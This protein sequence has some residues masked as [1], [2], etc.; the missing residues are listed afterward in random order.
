M[1]KD[2]IAL[3]KTVAVLGTVVP[4]LNTEVSKTQIV[5][6]E[7]GSHIHTAGT[8]SAI[9]ILPNLSSSYSAI[10]SGSNLQDS[11]VWLN[12]T[13]PGVFFLALFSSLLIC[14][15]PG[16]GVLEWSL[17]GSASYS[18]SSSSDSFSNLCLI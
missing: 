12:F 17:P 6:L 13:F 9:S 7:F 2:S 4:L 5:Y 14:T 16:L 3:G 8:G 10:I 15:K 18:C 11:Y 1:E